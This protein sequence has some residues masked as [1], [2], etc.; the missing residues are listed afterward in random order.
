MTTDNA[1]AAIAL[2]ERDIA[3]TW[4]LVN[5]KDQEIANVRR[6]LDTANHQVERLLAL[7]NSMDDDFKAEV[8]KLSDPN[9]VQ[10]NMLMGRI[11]KPTFAQMQFVYAAEFREA[12][13]AADA[14]ADGVAGKLDILAADFPQATSLF[15][16]LVTAYLATKEPK[17]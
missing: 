14:L 16:D 17:A 2:L 11:A 6:D 13:R 10:I 9:S 8:A 4:A 5:E 7:S 15:R 12:Q 3:D 1:A